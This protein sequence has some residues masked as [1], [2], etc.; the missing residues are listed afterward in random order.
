[1]KKLCAGPV[2]D[3][4]QALSNSTF[5][6][7]STFDEWIIEKPKNDV[8]VFWVKLFDEPNFKYLLKKRWFE[9]REGFL[10][11]DSIMQFIDETAQYLDEA[12]E[13][14]FQR[15]PILGVEL[16]RS[17]P[18]WESR[19]TYQHEV[20]YM[21]DFLIDHLSWMDGELESVKDKSFEIPNLVISEIMFDFKNNSEIEFIELVN[22]SIL[23]INLTGIY[24]DK[25]ITYTFPQV[26]NLKSGEKL[27][28]AANS[29]A[30]KNEY[31]FKPFGEFYGRLENNGEKLVINNSLG[32]EIDA[33]EYNNKKPWP[34]I[35]DADK[36]GSLELIDVNLDN[37]LAS[38]WVLSS[39][40]KGSPLNTYSEIIA[41]LTHNYN[42]R[43][44]PNPASELVTIYFPQDILKSFRIELF[45]MS[46][47]LLLQKELNEQNS[48]INISSI[49]NGTYLLKFVSLEQVFTKKLIV[50]H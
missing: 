29:E 3:F 16:W 34:V 15:W 31:G 37:S 18:G 12:Q 1:L 5:N 43:I 7:G 27:I 4:D 50:I 13:R 14:N 38:N 22:N 26:A 35:G 36:G 41:P 19:Y 24:F 11:T 40:P 45:N 46:G 25:G 48:T 2:W 9:L 20:D 49:E 28:L 8:P 10:H 47:K 23:P 42:P 30:F 39:N 32:I 6:E 21:K 17:L 44:Y 33:V